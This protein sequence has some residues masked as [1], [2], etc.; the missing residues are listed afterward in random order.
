MYN[1]VDNTSGKKCNDCILNNTI[2]P[3]C[4]NTDVDNTIDNVDTI[5]NVDKNNKIN[6][7]YRQLYNYC[8]YATINSCTDCLKISAVCGTCCCFCFCCCN[9]GFG[10]FIGGEGTGQGGFL[11]SN[12]PIDPTNDICCFEFCYCCCK[13]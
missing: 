4:I 11:G 8:L 10:F 2:N 13:K 7:N 9:P 5:N 12:P 6:R 3:L 1:N